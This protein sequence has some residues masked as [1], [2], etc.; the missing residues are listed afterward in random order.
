MAAIIAAAMS[1][2]SAELAS[3]STASIIDFYR[4]WWAADASDASLLWASRL[5]TGFW[6]L[7]A[8]VVAVYAANLRSLIEVV[9]RFGSY[10]TARCSASSSSPSRC[11]GPTAMGRSSGCSAA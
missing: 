2:I 7:F 6:G 5:A 9:N 1:T 4:R 11:R 8:S 10:S 3:L